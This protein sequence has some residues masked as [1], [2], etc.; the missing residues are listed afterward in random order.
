M[1]RIKDVIHI[2]GLSKSTIHAKSGKDGFPKKVKLTEKS[3]AWVQSEI[4]K[5]LEEKVSERDLGGPS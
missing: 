4:L 5:W 1:L 2:T 3:T